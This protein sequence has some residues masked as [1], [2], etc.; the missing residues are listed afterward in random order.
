MRY[1]LNRTGK[2]YPGT[3][4]QGQAAV[5]HHF[6]QLYGNGRVFREGLSQGYGFAP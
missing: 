1:G 2:L 4:I 6:C 3:E 5:K